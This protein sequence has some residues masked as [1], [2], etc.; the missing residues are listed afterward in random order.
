MQ[1]LTKLEVPPLTFFSSE[2]A[3]HYAIGSIVLSSV[4]IPPEQLVVT[5]TGKSITV[6]ASQV[7]A[8]L[9]DLT[10]MYKQKSFPYLRDRGSA[11]AQVKGLSLWLSFDVEALSGKS[12]A[13]E[14]VLEGEAAARDPAL[15]ALEE[16]EKNKKQLEAT[17]RVR[18]KT[19]LI[20]LHKAK[21][22][23]W[24]Y[25]MILALFSDRVKAAVEEYLTTALHDKLGALS[26]EVL[27]R[28][29]EYMSTAMHMP[30]AASAP[31]TVS[32]DKSM[33]DAD[34]TTA[35]PHNAGLDGAAQEA[36]REE[37][38]ARVQ[39]GGA[40][41]A[42]ME[43]GGRAPHRSQEDLEEEEQVG[44][45]GRGGDGN[46]QSNREARRVQSLRF[47]HPDPRSPVP[48][49]DASQMWGSAKET[50]GEGGHGVARGTAARNSS[51][52]V[53]T[54]DEVVE[55]VAGLTAWALGN[56]TV[57]GGI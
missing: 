28:A 26:A 57:F 43:W 52:A 31:S 13:G 5:V 19:L 50:R 53:A 54:I 40:G 21:V 29:E 46:L 37:A 42:G 22:P 1:Y 10:W 32:I 6:K 55:E 18:I 51:P 11:D 27:P 39:E 15:A 30:D 35:P 36:Q 8:T 3:F 23:P 24:M 2:R 33:P 4:S 20:T 16:K 25:N 41:R 9:R 45:G 12:S 14:G 47:G 7:S 34:D 17:N 44:G 48:G 56:E 49:S 38:G